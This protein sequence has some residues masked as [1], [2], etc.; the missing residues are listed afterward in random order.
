MSGVSPRILSE[1]GRYVSLEH[2]CP[3]GPWLYGPLLL[4]LLL[5]FPPREPPL[6]HRNCTFEDVGSI[7]ASY[8]PPTDNS[9]KSPRHKWIE[10]L[11][12]Q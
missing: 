1:L 4:L 5:L 11:V 7:D 10:S 8:D 12:D 2:A 3:K 9:P 6:Q